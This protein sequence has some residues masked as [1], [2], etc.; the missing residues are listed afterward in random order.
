MNRFS[1]TR[2][3]SVV[4]QNHPKLLVRYMKMVKHAPLVPKGYR[5]MMKK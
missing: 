3:L 1:L 4:I 2:K 5:R